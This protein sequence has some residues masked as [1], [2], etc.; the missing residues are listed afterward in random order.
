MRFLLLLIFLPIALLSTAQVSGKIIY[1]DKKDMHRNIPAEKQDIK[2]MIPPFNISK[3]ELIYS[4]NESI[5]QRT[6]EIESTQPS[7]GNRY[8]RMGREERTLYKNFTD[9]K[10]IDSRDF[11]QKKFLIKGFINSH[12]WK[13]GPGTKEILG[14]VCMKAYYQADSIT[15]ITAWF[16]PT[17]PISN[18]PLD[19][20][21]LPGLILQIDINNGEQTI[22]ATEFIKIDD[23]SSSISPP[24]K[25]K[26]ITSH[27]FEKIRKEKMKE[28][29]LQ[30]QSQGHMI[31]TRRYN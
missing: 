31:I 12:K 10:L 17:I 8:M 20:H 1:E 11:M 9:D 19:Y 21:G 14:N 26:E 22:T 16:T 7:Q 27:E 2:D 5:Y 28:M 18:G 29:N 13:V 23:S 25:G 4:P 24:D 6:A 30:Q 15:Y 3:W